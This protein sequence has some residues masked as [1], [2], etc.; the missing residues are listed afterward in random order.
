MCRPLLITGQLLLLTS[1]QS[2]ARLTESEILSLR[3][4]LNSERIEQRFGSYRIEVID[5][6]AERR[7]SHLSSVHDGQPVVRTVAEVRFHEPLP[8]A[9][10]RSHRTILDGASLGSTLKDAGW[11]IEKHPVA[12]RHSRR[13]DFPGFD[14]DQRFA[15]WTYRLMIKRPPHHPEPIPYALIIEV[16]HPDYLT[17]RDLRQL[18]PP[19]QP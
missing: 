16:Y 15:T 9:A 5:H 8:D 4:L 13:I 19:R 10:L 7:V 18:V 1:C 11:T 3:P 14:P 6:T 12:I 2:P 17:V